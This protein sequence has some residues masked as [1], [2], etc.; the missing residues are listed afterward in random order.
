MPIWNRRGAGRGISVVYVTHRQDPRFEWFV[1]GLARQIGDD[2]ELEVVLVDG[3]FSTERAERFCSLVADRFKLV[4]VAPKPTPFN[5]PHRLAASEYA[6]TASARNTGL[7]YA[8]HP[9]TVFVDDAS[10]LMPGWWAETQR[11]SRE[12]YVVAGAY[13]KH[14]D[15][16]VEAGTL[17][18]SRSEPSGI[19][20]RWSLGADRGLTRISGGELFGSSFGAPTSLLVGVNGLDE[21]CDP[22]GGEDYQLGIRLEWAGARIYYSRRMLTIESEDLHRDQSVPLR[23]DGLLDPDTYMQRLS[24]FGVTKRHVPGRCDSSHMALDILYGTRSVV[25]IGNYYRIADLRPSDLEGTVAGFP[26]TYWFDGRPLAGMRE[27]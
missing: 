22:T 17:R 12:G 4:H 19:D 8:S 23:V 27:S 25:S 9:Y 21:L 13:Q 2:D 7:V 6:A 3:H 1:D 26:D 10:V 14:W 24:G 15:M 5:G 16:R 11:A 18:F 20:A